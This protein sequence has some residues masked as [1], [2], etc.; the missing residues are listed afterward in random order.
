MEIGEIKNLPMKE[1][2][3]KAVIETIA[4]GWHFKNI[5]TLSD[6][7]DHGYKCGWDYKSGV[8]V[9]EDAYTC[10][11]LSSSYEIMAKQQ[12]EAG[13]RKR[14]NFNSIV[15]TYNGPDLTEDQS[16]WVYSS[17]ME[18][19]LKEK[20]G[21]SEIIEM[22]YAI[23]WMHGRE[24]NPFITESERLRDELS[25]PLDL[26]PETRKHVKNIVSEIF[27]KYDWLK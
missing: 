24:Q 22:M 19:K 17:T 6:V 8:K 13:F 23:A 10:V 15:I 18:K 4:Q 12:K 7:Y 27:G 1:E 16:A 9:Y 21:V 14:K 20:C 2:L 3:L 5:E 25:K 26:T 11:W